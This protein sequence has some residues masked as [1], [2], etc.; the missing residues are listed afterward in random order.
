[1]RRRGDLAGLAPVVT[2][3]C[4]RRMPHRTGKGATALRKRAGKRRRER[5]PGKKN[6]PDLPIQAVVS[7]GYFWSER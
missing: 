4:Q 2:G 5:T 3:R 7:I 1:M 6:G